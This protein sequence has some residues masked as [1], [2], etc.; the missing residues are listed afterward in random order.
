MPGYL[1]MLERANL[2]DK[3]DLGDRARQ[4]HENTGD[5]AA[6]KSRAAEH[7]GERVTSP[8][9]SVAGPAPVETLSEPLLSP[10]SPEEK[11]NMVVNLFPLPEPLARMVRAAGSGHL[12]QSAQLKSVHPGLSGL[13]PDLGVYVLSW[14]ALY[15]AGG[16]TA[17]TLSRLEAAY[18]AWKVGA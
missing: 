13:V 15:A 3:G 7:R 6:T 14:A 18:A 10:L 16:D 4:A 2:S 9:P 8:P 1:E 5:R 17:H 12:S 11:P